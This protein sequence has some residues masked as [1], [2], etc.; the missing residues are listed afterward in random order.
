LPVTAPE[1]PPPLA[2]HENIGSVPTF[3]EPLIA[4]VGSESHAF[5]PV[6]SSVVVHVGSL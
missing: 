2:A 1:T 5:G 3:D 6:E 4:F